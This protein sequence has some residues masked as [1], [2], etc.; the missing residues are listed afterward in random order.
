MALTHQRCSMNRFLGASVTFAGMDHS[1][2]RGVPERCSICNANPA[3]LH[4]RRLP[5]DS[6]RVSDTGQC[7]TACA[8]NMIVGLAQEEIDAW[9]ALAST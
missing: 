5:E 9:L 7:C 2:P 1:L 3:V 8:F 4:F 6:S